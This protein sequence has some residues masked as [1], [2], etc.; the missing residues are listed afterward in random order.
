MT[1]NTN[2][3]G[4]WFDEKVAQGIIVA[5][6]L[7]ENE[8]DCI[9]FDSIGNP[10]LDENGK[11]KGFDRAFNKF[12][13]RVSS[14]FSEKVQHKIKQAMY[15]A[16]FFLAGR[17]LYAAGSKGNFKASMSNCYIMPMPEDNIESI[18][19]TCKEMARI[20]S[21]GGGC[22]V[23]ISNLR[24]KDAIVNNSARASTGAVSFMDVFDQ[25]GRTIGA[26]G[27][28]AAILIGLNCNHPDVE[29]FL[30]IKRNNDRIQ[31]ANISILFT[32]EFMQAVKNNKEYELHFYVNESGKEIKRTINARDFFYKFAKEQWDWAEPGAL[33]IDRINEHHLLSEYPKEEYHVDV[34]NPCA[35]FQGNAYNSCNLAS[36]NLYNCIANPFTDKAR[37]DRSKFFELVEL[38]VA[39]LNETLD[40]GYDMQPLDKNRKCIDDWRSIGL[41]LFGVADALVAM[42]IRY[43]SPAANEFINDVGYY[44]AGRA[45]AA[46]CNIKKRF[47]KWSKKHVETSEFFKSIPFLDGDDLKQGLANGSLLS[48][49]PTGTISTMCGHTGGIEPIYQI[50]YERT[51][52]SLESSGKTFKV[53][54]KSVE[55]LLKHNGINPEDITIQEIKKKFPFVVDTYDIDPLERVDF[56]AS[57]QKYIDNAISSTINMREDCTVD[58]VFNTYLY[59]WEKGC[60]GITIFRDNCRRISILG[61]DKQHKHSSEESLLE[62]KRLFDRELNTLEPKKRGG[63]KSLWGRTFV[64]HTACVKKF[65]V[66]VNIKDGEIFEVFVGADTGCQANI[67]TITRLTSYALRLGGRVDDIIAELNSATCPACTAAMRNG[68]KTIN[69]SCAS[70]IADAL[71][72]MQNTINKDSIGKSGETD[73]EQE[74]EHKQIYMINTKHND[75]LEC[76]ECHQK[77][78]KPEGK[79]VNC[80]NCGY[81]KC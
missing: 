58:D 53:F 43:G 57:L 48:I 11:I 15:D 76:P 67:S 60:K 27:R 19:D 20:F 74:H 3:F 45:I 50:A 41:G 26:H 71:R 8:L 34:T 1:S 72:D 31:S 73:I 38:G 47:G 69:K 10:I 37:L 70:C 52:H 81:S 66:T 42:G 68:D 14:I 23:N 32:D 21:Y 54:A 62:A 55:H 44:M 16:D 63:V 29:E 24:P 4:N 46:S 28:R 65:Y 17:A 75:M 61:K 77:T 9:T 13:D 64:Y 49:A 7:H 59:A 35:E 33:F 18:F 78:L 40:Y 56:Q 30:E 79:C 36:I 80:T 5:K 2:R 22:G 51:T 6:Y 12:T 25:V 39:A